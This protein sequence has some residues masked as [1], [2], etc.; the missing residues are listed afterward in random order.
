L[1]ICH[2]PRR[3]WHFEGSNDW[4][5]VAKAPPGQIESLA[6]ELKDDRGIVRC[7]RPRKAVGT[8]A[9]AG[10]H[11]CQVPIIAI[12]LDNVDPASVPATRFGAQTGHAYTLH[13]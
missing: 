3:T 2:N 9:S 4:E 6:G 5:F 10:V 1:R 7:I 13:L 8:E 11:C 12:N